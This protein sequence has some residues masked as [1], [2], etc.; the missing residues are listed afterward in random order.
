VKGLKPGSRIR[1]T[2]WFYDSTR[3]DYNENAVNPPPMEGVVEEIPR[4]TLGQMA[5][6][7]FDS[8]ARLCVL[9][10]DTYEVLS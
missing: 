3:S 8:G 4:D 6:V 9:K 7:K 1:V 10:Q 2:R 5:W